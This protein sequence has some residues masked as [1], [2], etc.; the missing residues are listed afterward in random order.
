[1]K[2]LIPAILLTS[3]VCLAQEPAPV[4]EVKTCDGICLS[5]DDGVRISASL[6]ELKEIKE[7]KAEVEFTDTII[8]IRDLDDRVYING[9]SAKPVK[10]K[11]KLGPTI[12]RDM[13][14]TLPVQISYREKPPDSMFRLRIRAQAGLLV[15]EMIESFSGGVKDFWDASIGFDFFHIKSVN[16]AISPGIRSIGVGPGFDI[17]KNFGITAGYAFVYRG[18]DSSAFASAYFSFN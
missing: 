10:L 3:S 7:S 8:I 6:K 17:T 4:P 14:A 11:L 16:L 9:G 2:S 1:M 5:K 18:L 13:E 15:P 12:E